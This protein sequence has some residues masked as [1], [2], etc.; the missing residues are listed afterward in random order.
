M[1]Q[2][3]SVPIPKSVGSTCSIKIRITYSGGGIVVMMMLQHRNRPHPNRRP[4]NPS[5]SQIKNIKKKKKNQ[6]E[7]NWY[8]E[9]KSSIQLQFSY[10]R[11]IRSVT[12]AATGTTTL[13]LRHY[14]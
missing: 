6:S 11:S 9:Y 13:R 4:I 12:T 2:I 10:S 7:E 14:H 5:W 3:V 1:L 8:R